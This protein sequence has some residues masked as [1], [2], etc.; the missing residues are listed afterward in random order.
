V[1]H[2]PKR[3]GVEAVLHKKALERRAHATEGVNIRPPHTTTC[4]VTEGGVKC[5]ERT[6][7]VAKHCLKH[8]L[9]VKILAVIVFVYQRR[10]EKIK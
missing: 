10:F 6:L 9:E 1:N 5:G 8:I 4:I 7:P 3:S 2:Y